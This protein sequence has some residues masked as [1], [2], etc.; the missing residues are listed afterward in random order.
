MGPLKKYCYA[1]NPRCFFVPVLSVSRNEKADLKFIA[2]ALVIL[3]ILQ[4]SRSTP[5]YAEL[6]LGIIT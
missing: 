3:I 1:G 6:L 5:S 2:W 4:M